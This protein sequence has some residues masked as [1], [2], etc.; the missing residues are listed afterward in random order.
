M[1][2]VIP[3]YPDFYSSDILYDDIVSGN[4]LEDYTHPADMYKDFY[5]PDKMA[6]ERILWMDYSREISSVDAKD[7]FP[8]EVE[9]FRKLV[10]GEALRLFKEYFMGRDNDSYEDQDRL[11]EKFKKMVK[12]AIAAQRVHAEAM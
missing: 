2:R 7:L 5:S 8:G 9:L 11:K 6:M 4:F 3:D 1:L 10:A 12:A